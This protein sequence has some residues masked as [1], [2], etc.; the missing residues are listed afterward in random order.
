LASAFHQTEIVTSAPL[1]FIA[2]VGEEGEG[3]LRGIRHIYREYLHP[4]ASDGPSPKLSSLIVLDGAGASNIISQALGSRRFEIVIAG[5]GGHSWSDHGAPNPIV[6]ASLL[7]E[8]LYR[9]PLPAI[10]RTTLNI[11]TIEGGT[12]VNTIP[13]HATLKVDLRSADPKRLNELEQQLR[14]A[15]VEACAGAES[16]LPQP[17]P[18]LSHSIRLIGER[19]AG[20]LAASSP[21]LAAVRAV[22][23]HLG[24]Q[25]QLMR[26]STDANIPLSLGLEAVSLGG[27]GTGGGAHT[28]HEWFDPA[29]REQALKRLALLILLLAGL[30]PAASLQA[31]PDQV[32]PTP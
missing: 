16:H 28:L 8:A 27:G 12:S 7:V 22:D 5:P 9:I 2:N 32:V 24:I 19:P 15:V 14:H 10:P 20:E 18:R 11:G 17:R 6:A 31:V 4:N 26:A 1:L 30:P 29:G 21:L 3:D 23:A 25:S 13:E